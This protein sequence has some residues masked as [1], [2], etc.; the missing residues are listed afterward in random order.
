MSLVLILLLFGDLA[1]LPSRTDLETAF[2][3]HI[4]VGFV[5]DPLRARSH[6][7]GAWPEW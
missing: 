7:T 6:P 2:S 4:A 3:G 1:L 5:Q